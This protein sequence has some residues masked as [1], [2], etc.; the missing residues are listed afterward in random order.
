MTTF[1]CS[2]KHATHATDVGRWFGFCEIIKFRRK[3]TIKQRPL[4]QARAGFGDRKNSP[5]HCLRAQITN[6]ALLTPF[7]SALLHLPAPAPAPDHNQHSDLISPSQA[8]FT[9]LLQ[10]SQPR[11]PCSDLQPPPVCRVLVSLTLSNSPP[12]S[13]SQSRPS[14]LSSLSRTTTGHTR[15]PMIVCECV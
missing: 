4:D 13:L 5:Q 15:S 3:M 10:G 11:A 1:P 8:P 6:H 7:N 2:H 9:V 14:Y 12:R